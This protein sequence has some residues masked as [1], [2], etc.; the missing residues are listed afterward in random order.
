MKLEEL[1]NNS[2]KPTKRLWLC[3]KLSN[4]QSSVENASAHGGNSLVL[5]ISLQNVA[6]VGSAQLAL[7]YDPTV[8]SFQKTATGDLTSSYYISSHADDKKGTLNIAIAGSN[9]LKNNG[10]TSSGTAERLT[11]QTDTNGNYQFLNLLPG[12]YKLDVEQPRFKHVT[13]DQIQVRVD[14]ATRVDVSLEL[15]DM[16]QTIQVASNA[17][18]LQTE[19]AALNQVVEGRQVQDMPLNGRN[20]LNLVALAAG[21]VPLGSVR[22]RPPVTPALTS[23]PGAL[24]ITR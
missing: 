13:R 3:K 2:L 4:V 24:E 9:V 16:T 5:A 15:G 22:A 12:V 1:Q 23:V 7:N 21:V 20:V 19:S 11:A 8:F 17:A 18:L 10:I 6:G 14:N